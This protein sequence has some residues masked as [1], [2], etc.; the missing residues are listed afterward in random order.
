MAKPVK[1]TTQCQLSKAT[2][3]LIESRHCNLIGPSLSRQPYRQDHLESRGERRWFS[4]YEPLS[5]VE[6][7]TSRWKRQ[8]LKAGAHA[9]RS[10]S[11]PAWATQWDLIW[12]WRETQDAPSSTCDRTPLERAFAEHEGRTIILSQYSPSKFAQIHTTFLLMLYNMENYLSP[13]SLAEFWI[14]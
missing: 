5:K 6:V 3:V 13:W 4:H 12:G 10:S 2:C 1:Q 9:H 11:R 14:L 8:R 7:Q